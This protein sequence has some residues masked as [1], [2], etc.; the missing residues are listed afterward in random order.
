MSASRLSRSRTDSLIR[1]IIKRHS[2]LKEKARE[3]FQ[4]APEQCCMSVNCS[5]AVSF[6]TIPSQR[7]ASRHQA[8]PHS[9]PA[10]L[11]VCSAC[12]RQLA[13][14]TTQDV[15]R[16]FYPKRMVQLYGMRQ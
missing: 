11:A 5:M 3:T 10:G 13:C 7:L 12:L 6:A 9:S 16:T 2:H 4:R 15:Y 8:M 14:L 1:V